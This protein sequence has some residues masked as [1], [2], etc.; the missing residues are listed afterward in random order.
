MV[1][2]TSSLRR[3]PP[4]I[5]RKIDLHQRWLQTD[6][7]WGVRIGCDEEP[8]DMTGVILD[9][10]DLS[11]GRLSNVE[12]SR[13]SLRRAWFIGAELDG[14]AFVDCDLTGGARFDGA[15]LEIANFAGAD[16]SGAHFDKAETT[17]T[18]WTKEQVNAY[19][20]SI[21][22]RLDIAVDN[23]RNRLAEAKQAHDVGESACAAKARERLLV[24]RRERMR[25]SGAG[26]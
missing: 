11:M 6:G 4:E 26:L 1:A 7:E 12:F 15:D 14:A 5:Q 3:P 17:N 16:I 13:S 10:I 19:V 8:L 18:L 22:A 2:H 24:G 20:A 9:G 23:R 25:L 21:N